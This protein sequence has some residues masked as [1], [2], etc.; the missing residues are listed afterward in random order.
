MQVHGKIASQRL[1]KLRKQSNT[2]QTLSCPSTRKNFSSLSLFS[3]SYTRTTA[4]APIDD[5][6]GGVMSLPVDRCHRRCLRVT[7]EKRRAD[8]RRCK[9]RC[10]SMALGKPE[11]RVA[12]VA[13]KWQQTGTLEHK[14]PERFAAN[15]RQIHSTLDVF[16]L[17]NSATGD[18]DCHRGS[19]LGA[20][21]DGVAV[22]SGCGP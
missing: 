4:S 19:A 21:W 15:L 3:H 6:T 13:R 9:T 7:T 2:G 12:V 22:I 11:A 20:R 14:V 5:D 1:R 10:F 18:W 16:D 17:R 8:Q